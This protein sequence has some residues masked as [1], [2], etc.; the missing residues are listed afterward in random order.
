MPGYLR[1]SR[2]GSS[3][4]GIGDQVRVQAEMLK[5]LL[6]KPWRSGYPILLSASQVQSHWLFKTSMGDRRYT[7]SLR[8]ILCSDRTLLATP[9]CFSL[10]R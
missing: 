8:S 6:G 2:K 4:V 10:L 5:E 1:S 3:A 9:L 7:L